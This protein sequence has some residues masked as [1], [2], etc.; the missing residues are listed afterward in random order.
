MSEPHDEC[1]LI[2]GLYFIVQ[3]ETGIPLLPVS[4]PLGQHAPQTPT[5]DPA[6]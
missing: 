2:A 4:A 5:I 1:R 3:W 6:G